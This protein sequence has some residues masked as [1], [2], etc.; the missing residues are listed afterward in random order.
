MSVTMTMAERLPAER[1]FYSWY[2]IGMAVL[3]L[4]GFS[5]SFYLPGIVVFPRPTPTF[6]PLMYVHGFVFT[7]WMLLFIV[8]TQLIASGNRKLHISL[9]TGGF[10]LGIVMTVIMFMI[11][12][13]QIARANGP[14]FVSP[15]SWSALP[16]FGIPVFVLFLALGWKYRYQAQ[17][18]KRLMLLLALMMM[19]PAVGRLPL[20]PPGV[21]SQVVGSALAWLLIVPLMVW[22]RRTLGRLH[23]VTV[24]GAS[25]MLGMLV[26]RYALWRTQAWQDLA[27][28]LASMV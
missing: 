1:R 14:P 18:H 8:Q 5:S 28:R 19:E 4:A 21:T 24:M 10:V 25:V 12:G 11:A 3:V 15:Q 2:V 7:A 9:G 6:T 23:G 22:D 17:T 20:G 26:L 13:A 27:D 16:F